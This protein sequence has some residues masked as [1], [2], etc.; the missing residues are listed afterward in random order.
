MKIAVSQV[1][2][3]ESSFEKDI[4]DFAGGGC[5]AVELW[6]GKLDAYLEK[7]TPD[8]L[9]K[10]LDAYHVVTPV[11]AFQ[12]GLLSSQG[13][14][15][16]QHWEGFRRRLDQCQSL[17]IGTLVLAADIAAPIDEQTVE[18]VR[19]SLVE[20]A[21]L[22][23]EHSV[24]LALEFQARA[25]MANNLQTAAALVEEVGS[26]H[27]GLCFDAFHYYVGPSKP[28]DL[29]YLTPDSLFH[30][31]LCDLS[32]VPREFAA[33]ADRILP[34]DGDIDFGPIVHALGSIS[35]GGYVSVE[36]MNPQIWRTP[37]RQFAEIALS[38]LAKVLGEERAG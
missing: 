29:A 37:A 32:G 12:G 14:F 28:E 6:T 17:E 3:L 16:R 33:D 35:Y 9:R 2:S 11:A 20:A 30:V 38:A 10:L 22:A 21:R 4:E 23:G 34:G 15:R 1:C 24:R 25:A 7:H 13:E 8:E 27:L 19:I 18:R 5:Q 26:T 36:L 31:Q